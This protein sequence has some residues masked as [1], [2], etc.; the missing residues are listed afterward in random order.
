MLTLMQA[1]R[2]LQQCHHMPTTPNV[3]KESATWL[4]P[5]ESAGSRSEAVPTRPSSASPIT[6]ELSL[7]S[8]SCPH[9]YS[10]V[11]G[12]FLP[13]APS[14]SLQSIHSVPSSRP[15]HPEANVGHWIHGTL[16][17]ALCRQALSCARCTSLPPAPL[18]ACRTVLQHPRLSPL[19]PLGRIADAQRAASRASSQDLTKAL[20]PLSLLH[21][22]LLS[23]LRVA[24]GTAR[25]P[26]AG[27]IRPAM[28][29][30]STPRVLDHSRQTKGKGWQQASHS[31]HEDSQPSLDSTPE[32]DSA[33]PS[34]C[35]VLLQRQW[36]LLTSLG[37]FR[38]PGCQL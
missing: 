34:D 4:R 19:P 37:I 15:Q 7:V 29:H 38:S 9:R 18:N 26:Q 16:P 31:L 20:V 8:E 32:L 33:Q 28:L 3:W 14:T 17:N 10:A 5:R 21:P 35:K 23:T 1:Q 6:L 25:W 2:P 27:W 24:A 22:K 12:C 11:L 30:A 13:L 36:L